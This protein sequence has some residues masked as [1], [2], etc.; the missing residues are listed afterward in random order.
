MQSSFTVTDSLF[1]LNEP[2]SSFL[3]QTNLFS[4]CCY[5]LIVKLIIF[6]KLFTFI[7]LWWKILTNYFPHLLMNVEYQVSYCLLSNHHSLME[8]L[9]ML[10]IQKIRPSF[11]FSSTLLSSNER[12][13]PTIS[14]QVL[15]DKSENIFSCLLVTVEVY[16]NLKEQQCIFSRK[17]WS[18]L[19]IKI[20]QTKHMIPL[21]LLLISIL[22]IHYSMNRD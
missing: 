14:I 2:V 15:E 4:L 22:R 3:Y 20:T 18:A 12:F 16:I 13:A 5:F 10:F 19:T 11:S 7:T 8:T 17:N 9:V 6:F 1:I 21:V